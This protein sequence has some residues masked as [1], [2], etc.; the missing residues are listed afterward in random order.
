MGKSSASRGRLLPS[1]RQLEELCV[2][3]YR[4]YSDT[5]A[6][7]CAI[8]HLFSKSPEIAKF[9]GIERE[10]KNCEGSPIRPDVVA[11]YD[12]D[13]KG[14]IFELKWS[15][16]FTEDYLEKKIKELRKYAIPCSNWQNPSD[17]VDFHDLVLICHIDDVQRAV[18]MIKRLSTDA[19][20][21]FF[22]KDGFAVWSW[23]ITPP[24]MGERKE[25]LR[26]F[27]V[28]GKTRNQQIES[29]I[30]QPGGILFSEDV[31][32][33]LRWSFTFVR[34]KPPVQ[35]V[36]TVL[37]QNIFP[38]FQRSPDRVN[39]NIHIDMLWERT[40]TFFPSWHEFDKETIQVKRRWIREALQKFL[41]LKLCHKIV[42][43]PNWWIIP[44][45]TLKTRKP[46]QSVL[47]KLIS[48]KYLE[49]LKK[50]RRKGRR[51]VGPIRPKGPRREPPLTD[52]KIF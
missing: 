30:N 11:I 23:T 45:P 7:S 51:R 47:C 21:D 32:T 22:G 49:N 50:R 10:L 20:Y 3:E 39:Y 24:K 34:E 16:P 9:I 36:M 1:L 33:F 15:L 14:L 13:S 46:I 44:I 38:T 4:K 42:G 37:I 29:K 26:L 35:Y 40:K 8:Y 52:F 41:E 12:G 31:L 6:V 28:Y 18:D 17:A 43:K 5:V 48:K 2:K 27:P 19:E 25:E